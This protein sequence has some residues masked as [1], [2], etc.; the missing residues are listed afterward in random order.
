MDFFSFL[1]LNKP[2]HTSKSIIIITSSA[3]PD[4]LRLRPYAR[5]STYFK[6]FNSPI[7]YVAILFLS[8]ANKLT[9]CV[10]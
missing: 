2:L 3:L 7:G 5:M 9:K 10:E 1:S 4:A 8:S 6:M